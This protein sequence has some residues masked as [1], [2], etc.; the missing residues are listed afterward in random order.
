MNVQRSHSNNHQIQISISAIQQLQ[1]DMEQSGGDTSKLA[2]LNS[3]QYHLK[4]LQNEITNKRRV[5]A[6]SALDFGQ[7]WIFGALVSSLN[8]QHARMMDTLAKFLAL[9]EPATIS[10]TTASTV[11]YSKISAYATRLSDLMQ[12]SIRFE[13]AITDQAPDTF[14]CNH[15]FTGQISHTTVH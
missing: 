12:S 6:D 2:D 3:C 11:N 7:H 1:Y 14:A 13:K 5:W 15:Q 9:V 10:N 4:L 8:F